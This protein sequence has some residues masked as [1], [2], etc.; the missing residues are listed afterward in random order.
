MEPSDLFIDAFGRLPQAVRRAVHGL[1]AGVL[2]R[3]PYP[4][5]NSIS[6]LIWHLARGEDA[7]IA[8]LAGHEQAWTAEGWFERVGLPLAVE[9][10][11]YG[12]TSEQV[13]E[14]RV[15]SAEVLLDYYQAVHSRTA[16]FVSGVT[17]QDLD[18]VVDTAWDPPVTLGVRLVSILGDGL[19]HVGQAAYLR[20]ML[21]ADS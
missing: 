3:R 15:Q 21:L 16:A 1:D 18:K 12:H 10:T 19:E 2:N 5:G 6:W 9:D 4:Q 7:Q 17:G 8:P 20:G 14:V 13:A 11:G